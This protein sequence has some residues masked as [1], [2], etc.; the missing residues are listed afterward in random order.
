MDKVWFIKINGNKEGPYNIQELRGD[1]RVTPDTLVWRQ[2]F[3]NWVPMRRVPELNQVFQ[4][5]E[6]FEPDEETKKISLSIPKGRD[7][8]ALD[9]RRESPP[10]L[11]WLLIILIIVAYFL[12]RL[13]NPS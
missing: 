9:F 11:F 2:G 8:L 10:I 12:F 7:E 6:P 3:A 4:D 5:A 1:P 13:E